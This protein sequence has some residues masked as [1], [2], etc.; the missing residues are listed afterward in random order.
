MND[1]QY[2]NY[3]SCT[4]IYAM[5]SINNPPNVYGGEC[6]L[7]CN[8]STCTSNTKPTLNHMHSIYELT[9]VFDISYAI[10]NLLKKKLKHNFS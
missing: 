4:T 3:E 7:N 8:F 2:G 9:R 10:R 6:S 1:A 5:K